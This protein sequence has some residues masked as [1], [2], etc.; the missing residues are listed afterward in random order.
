MRGSV[1]YQMFSSNNS[2]L[3]FYHC[4]ILDLRDNSKHNCAY[5]K[6]QQQFFKKQKVLVLFFVKGYSFNLNVATIPRASP[7]AHSLVFALWFFNEPYKSRSWKGAS[8]RLKRLLSCSLYVYIYIYIFAKKQNKNLKKK[9]N[10]KTVQS[11]YIEVLDNKLQYIKAANTF[12]CVITIL[13]Q[14]NV[15]I[16]LVLNK[17]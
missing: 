16:F 17:M 12:M 6:L 8:E 10:N 3:L 5:F 14:Y 9:C 4:L 15:E 1:V 13:R 2:R 7:P 11:I